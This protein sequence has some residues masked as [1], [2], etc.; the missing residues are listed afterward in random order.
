MLILSSAGYSGLLPLIYTAYEQPIVIGLF[1]VSQFFTFTLFLA[2]LQKCHLIEKLYILSSLPLV[3][4][5][6][7]WSRILH[8]GLPFLSLLIQSC[9]SACGIIYTFVCLNLKT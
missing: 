5:V 1:L 8:P 7:Q 9:Y 4:Y 3:C 6:Q 2:Q